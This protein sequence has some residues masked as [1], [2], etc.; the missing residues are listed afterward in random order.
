MMN[1][2]I[3]LAHSSELAIC[4]ACFWN[5]W[6]FIASPMLP[7]IFNFP[8]KKGLLG[9]QFSSHEVNQ[10]IVAHCQGNIRF[11][12]NQDSCKM[13]KNSEGAVLPTFPCKFDFAGSIF[14]INN[15]GG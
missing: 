2:M 5:S 8:W 9:I 14:S 15:P 10:L 12:W 7:W 4:E 6:S 13:L 1:K 3:N 11:F